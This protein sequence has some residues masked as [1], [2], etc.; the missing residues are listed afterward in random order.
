[1]TSVS[2]IISQFYIKVLMSILLQETVISVFIHGIFS[3]LGVIYSPIFHSFH[4]ITFLFI[5]E[6][7]KIVFYSVIQNL[8]EM[9]LIFVYSLFIV[10]TYSVIALTHFA[11]DFRTDETRGYDICET[12][13]GCFLNVLDLGLRNGGG[14]GE[15]MGQFFTS[16]SNFKFKI[17]FDLSFFIL[18]NVIALNMLFGIII[19]TFSEMREKIQS[20]SKLKN[21]I[22]NQNILWQITV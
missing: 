16:D 8:K 13:W 12:L 2:R 14:I 11:D 9:I 10:Y 19:D 22:I 17:I 21:L 18:I 7:I 5:S 1:M 3:L 6:K 4:L 20:K 15:S